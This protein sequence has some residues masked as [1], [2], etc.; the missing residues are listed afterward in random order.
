[1]SRSLCKLLV[2]RWSFCGFL[3]LK[4]FV[5]I[6]FVEVLKTTTAKILISMSHWVCGELLRTGRRLFVCSQHCR[7]HCVQHSFLTQITVKSPKTHFYAHQNF[8]TLTYSNRTGIYHHLHWKSSCRRF[9]ST[10]GHHFYSKKQWLSFARCALKLCKSKT[11]LKH[12]FCRVADYF[13][14]G[15]TVLDTVFGVCVLRHSVGGVLGEH[16]QEHKAWSLLVVV[17]Q[18]HRNHFAF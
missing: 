15:I 4:G 13:G 18:K 12:T 14:C 9:Y 2:A 8:C 5:N 17:P 6:R 3:F 10:P 16:A 1:M 11:H 7:E